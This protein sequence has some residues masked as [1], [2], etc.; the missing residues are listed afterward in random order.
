MVAPVNDLQKVRNVHR[1]MLKAVI[2]SE[3]KTLPSKVP[4]PPTVAAL[5]DGDS[6]SD[7]DVWLLVP[8]TPV[9][10]STAATGLGVK[11]GLSVVHRRADDAKGRGRCGR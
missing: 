10:Q 8:E 3:A 2:Q 1:D 7:S 11:S 9:P 5:D 6:Y 4:S